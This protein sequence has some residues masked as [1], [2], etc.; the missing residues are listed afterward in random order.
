MNYNNNIF[1]LISQYHSLLRHLWF[2]E[3]NPERGRSP[4]AAQNRFLRFTVRKLNSI[5]AVE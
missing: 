2:K 3:Q 5:T 4:N 1:D